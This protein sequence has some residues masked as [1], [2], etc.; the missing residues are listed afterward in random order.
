MASLDDYFTNSVGLG[1][2]QLTQFS[3]LCLVDFVDGFAVVFLA[4]LLSILKTEWSLTNSDLITLGTTYFVGVTIGLIFEALACDIIGRKLCLS[5]SMVL[6][7]LSV[8]AHAVATN[9]QQVIFLRFV[10]GFLFGVSIPLSL[11]LI[12]E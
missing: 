8:L 6:T 3:I 11:I 9:I 10:F 5:V 2:G 12:S 7:F 4:I 1:K